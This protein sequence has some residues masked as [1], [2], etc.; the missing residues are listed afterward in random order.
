MSH[1]STIENVNEQNFFDIWTRIAG[2]KKYMFINLWDIQ[3]LMINYFSFE[4]F[5]DNIKKQKTT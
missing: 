5:E 1:L 4:L 3:I 2:A